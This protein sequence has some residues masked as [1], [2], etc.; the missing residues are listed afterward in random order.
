MT[1]EPSL[2]NAAERSGPPDIS[3]CICCYQSARTLG[4]TLEA[5]TRQTLPKERWEIVLVD[6]RC[7]DTTVAI[8]RSYLG[9]LPLTIIHEDKPG[10]ANARAAAAA[11]VRGR[12]SV[13][14]D[15]DNELVPDQ[16]E[17]VLARFEDPELEV[18]GCSTRLPEGT[19]LD[20]PYVADRIVCYAVGPQWGVIEGKGELFSV[21]EVWGAGLSVRT[22][23]YKATFERFGPMSCLGRFGKKQLA[24][25][26]NEL[27][28]RV[29][30]LGGKIM[31]S[32]KV[33]LIHHVDPRRLN[34]GAIRN[35]IRNYAQAYPILRTYAIMREYPQLRSRGLIMLMHVKKLLGTLRRYRS[36]HDSTGAVFLWCLRMYLFPTTWRACLAV[37]K[38][39]NA[40]RLG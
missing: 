38:G 4:I 28:L 29:C 8:A 16:L 20:D 25:E 30:L 19:V 37:I 22:R 34:A 12:I 5:L 14:V 10:L 2:P 3:I 17:Y 23:T 11:A 36:K 18:L 33:G 21:S 27:C 35:N 15:D 24:G 13:F 9:R 1:T 26:D 7:T 31:A 39:V 6:N 32:A 40:G